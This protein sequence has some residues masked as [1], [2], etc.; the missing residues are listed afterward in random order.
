MKNLL[1]G[2]ELTTDPALIK[3][4][5]W[6]VVLTFFIMSVLYLWSNHFPHIDVAQNALALDQ[7]IPFMSWTIT[8]YW[9]VLLVAF[10]GALMIR[11]I[12]HLHIVLVINAITF[13]INFFIWFNFPVVYRGDNIIMEHSVSGVN[14]DLFLILY[15]FDSPANSFP[16]GHVSLMCLVAW[17]G[18][19]LKSYA[20]YIILL[21]SALGVLSVF[22]TRQ[23]TIIDA[24]GG[25][26]TV[27]L[28]VVI[29]RSFFKKL[30][31]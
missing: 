22:T 27:L 26:L 5:S 11:N 16:S 20:G 4:N 29:V 21:I 18:Y 13:L 19:S 7:Q 1:Q 24:V 17:V 23:H 6:L 12:K 31:G 25:L 2:I 14:R 3:R 10:S 15:Y 28:A 30:P 8:I 9:A